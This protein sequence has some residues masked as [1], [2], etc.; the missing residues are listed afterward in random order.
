MRRRAFIAGLTA[1]AIMQPALAQQTARV[2]RIAVISPSVPAADLSETGSQPN[3]RAFFQRL[4]E[5]GYI[6]GGTLAIERYSGEEQSKSYAELAREALRGNPDL[7]FVVNLRLARE[8][9][10]AMKTVPVVVIAGD[11][12]FSGAASSSRPSGNVTGVIVDAGVEMAGK[13]FDLLREVVPSAS[14]IAWIA[15][16]GLWGSH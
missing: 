2:Y 3:Y 6:E 16:P 4:R 15:S 8:V 9:K 11:P 10:I 5:L 7:I 1:S 12:A 14:R 13:S